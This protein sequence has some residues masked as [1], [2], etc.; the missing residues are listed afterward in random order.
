MVRIHD[1][2]AK[3]EVEL[4]T[5]VPGHVSMY[6]CGPTVYDLAHVGHGRT[7]IVYDVMRR[8]GNSSC[9][10][11]AKPGHRQTLLIYV[12]RGRRRCKFVRRQ[13]TQRIKQAWLRYRECK[14]ALRELRTLNRKEM[15]LLR[16]QIRLRDVRLAVGGNSGKDYPQ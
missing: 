8:C 10:C 9:H 1:S 3:R 6:V 15:A 13:D 7:A 11:A 5:R 4:T 14:K 16:V 12:E 2:L